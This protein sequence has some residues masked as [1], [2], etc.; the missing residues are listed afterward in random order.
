[1]SASQTF[2]KQD[3]GEE[4]GRGWG[5]EE[6]LRAPSASICPVVWMR[7]NVLLPL[8][9]AGALGLGEGRGPHGLGA[10]HAV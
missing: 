1:M 10:S 7:L 8:L 6:A 9:N 5:S 3:K 4:S 2:T